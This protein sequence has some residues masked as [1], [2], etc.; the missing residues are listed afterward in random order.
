M[1]EWEEGRSTI[2]EGSEG[3]EGTEGAGATTNP[4]PRTRLFRNHCAFG[5]FPDDARWLRDNVGF[6]SLNSQH[7]SNSEKDFNPFYRM[8]ARKTAEVDVDKVGQSP[9]L[10]TELHLGDM[11]VGVVGVG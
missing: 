1:N 10:E 11:G 3:F 5:Y 8:A 6:V 4:F 2:S 9:S 7:D